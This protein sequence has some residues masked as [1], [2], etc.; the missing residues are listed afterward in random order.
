MLDHAGIC[1]SHWSVGS[2]RRPCK[3]RIRART[4]IWRSGNRLQ[5][6][7]VPYI[8]WRSVFTS[9]KTLKHIHSCQEP[10]CVT[11]S[12]YLER[13]G[14]TEAP[15]RDSQSADQERVVLTHVLMRRTA[16]CSLH[17][18]RWS[19][20]RVHCPLSRIWQSS[21]RSCLLH[22]PCRS[23]EVRTPSHAYPCSLQSWEQAC[24]WAQCT[25]PS[26]MGPAH[27]TSSLSRQQADQ[28]P[29][30]ISCLSMTDVESGKFSRKVK[31]C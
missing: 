25:H 8:A 20:C 16:P 26:H 15:A 10:P 3:Q 13:S 12:G 23:W 19:D 27:S 6:L 9:R 7:I 11:P 18:L 5:V 21:H 31:I 1:C 2:C 24:W 29:S 22:P 4:S 28:Q 17:R 30:P 14:A